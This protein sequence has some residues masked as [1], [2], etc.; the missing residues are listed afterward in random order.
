MRTA[1]LP[2][3]VAADVDG[4]IERAID[5]GRDKDLGV[6]LAPLRQGM[7]DRLRQAPI[8]DCRTFAR[9]MEREYDRM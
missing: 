8:C 9:D 5:L 6:R 2:E 3:Y 1:G 7:R 4:Y